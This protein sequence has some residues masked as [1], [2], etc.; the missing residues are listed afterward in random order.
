MKRIYLAR[1]KYVEGEDVQF[2]IVD[3]KDYKTLKKYRWHNA[4][5]YAKTF[6]NKRPVQMANLL[7]TPPEGFVVDHINGSG[8]DNRRANL[9]IVTRSENARRA[10]AAKGNWRQRWKVGYSPKPSKIILKNSISA[11]DKNGTSDI[12]EVKLG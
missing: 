9:E 10:H 5:G 7:M 1:R 8:L 6:I 4:G 12:I 11:I 3:N 2:T